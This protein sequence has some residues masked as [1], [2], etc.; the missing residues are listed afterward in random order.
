MTLGAWLT[1]WTAERRIA[2]ARPS[3][4]SGYRTDVKHLVPLSDVR[5][6]KLTPERI[7]L[8]WG[9]LLASGL[10][11][12]S[13]RHVRRTLSAALKVAVDRGRLIRNP[14]RLAPC[15]ADT[16]PDVQPPTH[17][18]AQ[19]LLNAAADVRG[20]VRWAI[21]WPWDFARAGVLGLKWDDLDLDAAT[22]RI[23]RSLDRVRY[24]HPCSA[25]KQCGRAATCP[26]PVSTGGAAPLTTRGSARTLALPGVLVA[27]LRSHRANQ[28]R[29]RLP[30]RICGRAKTGSSPTTSEEFE[31]FG[32]TG[33]SGERSS[34][35]RASSAGYGSTT[36]GIPPRRS[37]CCPTGS[38]S[39]WASTTCPTRVMARRTAAA[40]RCSSVFDSTSSTRTPASSGWPM[41]PR[42]GRAL[43]NGKSYRCPRAD[44]VS[45]PNR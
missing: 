8:L 5:L 36:S 13:V 26:Q 20:G 30:L 35:R 44:T 9:D 18:E 40:S 24:S 27:M 32:P 21:A 41:M 17:E 6:D 10:S 19:Q 4:I 15:P 38:S 11:G 22:V 3:T 14:A 29:E 31:R 28:N 16:T 43:L 7:G 12:G 37:A 33:I 45:G 42:G 34:P 25:P 23:R 39:P 2:G 1:T